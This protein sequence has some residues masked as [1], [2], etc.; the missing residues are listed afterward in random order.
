MHFHI[1]FN[2]TYMADCK[3]FS[4]KFQP[5]RSAFSVRSNKTET[6]RKTKRKWQSQYLPDEDNL[7]TV[8]SHNWTTFLSIVDQNQNMLITKSWEADDTHVALYILDKH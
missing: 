5:L 1:M 7:H 4:F 6:S 3:M 8:F 2:M